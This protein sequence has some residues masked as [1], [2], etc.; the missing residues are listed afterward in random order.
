MAERGH[1]GC[2]AGRAGG[3]AGLTRVEAD[4]EV[5]EMTDPSVNRSSSSDGLRNRSYSIMLW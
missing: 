4:R 2:L 1:A 5:S 3:P